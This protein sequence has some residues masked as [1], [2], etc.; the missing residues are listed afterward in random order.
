MI[1]ASSPREKM[2]GTMLRYIWRKRDMYEPVSGLKEAEGNDIVSA[3]KRE[4]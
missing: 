1:L 3:D 2:E 4:T